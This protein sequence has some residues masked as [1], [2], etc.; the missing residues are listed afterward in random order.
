MPKIAVDKRKSNP[1][2]NKFLMNRLY[3]T[4]SKKQEEGKKLRKDIAKKSKARN[5]IPSSKYF[6]T[7]SISKA[8]EMYEKGIIARQEKESKIAQ[9]KE[10]R[11]LE[12]EIRDYGKISKSQVGNMYRKG[13]QSLILKEL[14]IAEKQ[15]AHAGSFCTAEKESRQRTQL[16][17]RYG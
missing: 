17:R 10:K 16:R 1:M 2:G 11:L 9:E 15:Q 14:K 8:Q 5:S 7:I 13:L 12:S 6:G 4:S 3:S